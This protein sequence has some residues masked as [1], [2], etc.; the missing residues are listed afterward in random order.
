MEIS[1]PECNSSMFDLKC[2]IEN[3]EMKGVPI[4][5][6]NFCYCCVVCS[7]EVETAKMLDRNLERAHKE[8]EYIMEDKEKACEPTDWSG[9]SDPIKD[10]SKC[11]ELIRSKQYGNQYGKR[12]DYKVWRGYRMIYL[13]LSILSNSMLVMAALGLL[14]ICASKLTVGE[15]SNTWFDT[16]MLLSSVTWLLIIPWLGIYFFRS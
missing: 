14:C 12:L 9:A 6:M 5:Y 13:Q 15:S 8:Y 2:C 7:T 4:R 3:V 1:C 11:V 10:I 16:G